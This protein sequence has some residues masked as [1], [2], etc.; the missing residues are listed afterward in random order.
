MTSLKTQW[1]NEQA[2]SVNVDAH[3]V[4]NIGLQWCLL[5]ISWLQCTPDISW[6]SFPAAFTSAF[7][8]DN[9]VSLRLGTN[10]FVSFFVLSLWGQLTTFQSD[11][12]DATGFDNMF[13]VKNQVCDCI[14]WIKFSIKFSQSTKSPGSAPE[15]NMR[16]SGFT[17]PH[18]TLTGALYALRVQRSLLDGLPLQSSWGSTI[19]GCWLTHWCLMMHKCV[20]KLGH[21]WFRQWLGT[22][23]AP[24]HYLK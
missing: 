16:Q 6:S 21:H 17:S 3:P 9:I 2:V 7:P 1:V 19:M 4:S 5:L 14:Y 20:S 18:Y 13:K 24:C 22:F 23:L 12:W 8:I 11:N 10:I 15:A